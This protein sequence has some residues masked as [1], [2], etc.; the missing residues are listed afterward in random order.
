MTDQETILGLLRLGWSAR[1]IARETNHRR[2]TIA[3]YGIAAGL[4]RPK[5]ATPKDLH[6]HACAT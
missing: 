5:P 2:E 4:I 3:R 1:R 6:R